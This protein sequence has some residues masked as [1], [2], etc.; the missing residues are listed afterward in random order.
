MIYG[1]EIDE[2]FYICD[3]DQRFLPTF[4][5]RPTPKRIFGVCLE[6]YL[7]GVDGS[8]SL[9]RQDSPWRFWRAQSEEAIKAGRG[10]LVIELHKGNKDSLW[11]LIDWL[12]GSC[13]AVRVM[14]DY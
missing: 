7:Q 3:P 8:C 11:E 13:T 10:E 5:P 6:D 14:T 4:Q 12:N 9:P 1:L 2:E